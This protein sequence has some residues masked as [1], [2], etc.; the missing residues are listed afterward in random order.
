M[1]HYP[2]DLLG[3]GELVYQPTVSHMLINSPSDV[4]DEKEVSVENANGST[5]LA[6]DV[7][8][9]PHKCRL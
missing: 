6:C 2:N 1:V 4:E 3:K 7:Q 8:V 9:V 5:A